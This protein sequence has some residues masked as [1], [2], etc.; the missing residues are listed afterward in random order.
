MGRGSSAQ[1]ST[2]P[3][4]SPPGARRLPQLDPRPPAVREL[5][6]GGLE[7]VTT[8]FTVATFA[9]TGPIVLSKRLIVSTDTFAAEARSDCAVIDALLNG[10]AK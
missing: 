4:R 7:G 3:G 8:E 2:A 6:A 10:G 5:D 9:D 1:K